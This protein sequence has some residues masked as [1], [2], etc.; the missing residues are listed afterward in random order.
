MRFTLVPYGLEDSDS[1]DHDTPAPPLPP[2]QN[3][4]QEDNDDAFN[5][6]MADIASL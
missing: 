3:E 6:F 1:S 2:P 4:G 5:Q